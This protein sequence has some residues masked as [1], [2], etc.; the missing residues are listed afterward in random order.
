MQRKVI[1]SNY[2]VYLYR[3]YSVLGCVN[4]KQLEKKYSALFFI[5]F[6]VQ[7]CG[8]SHLGISP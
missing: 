4:R 1:L 3:V 6:P 2:G 7:S 5:A 8:L